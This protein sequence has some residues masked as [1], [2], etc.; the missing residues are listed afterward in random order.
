MREGKKSR[1][2]KEKT[3]WRENWKGAGEKGGRE[4]EENGG[5]RSGQRKEKKKRDEEDEETRRIMTEIGRWT[6]ENGEE[7]D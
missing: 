1:N 5:E 2:I 4:K 7:E 3:R 6:K